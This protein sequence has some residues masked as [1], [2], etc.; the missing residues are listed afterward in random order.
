VTQHK[1]H[2]WGGW[3]RWTLSSFDPNK[4]QI[5]LEMIWGCWVSRW[6]IAPGKAPGGALH[7][8]VRCLVSWTE[9]IGLRLSFL[10]KKSKLGHLVF[11]RPKE[12]VLVVWGYNHIRPELN[13]IAKISAKY[14]LYHFP[15]Y[16][17]SGHIMGNNIVYGIISSRL[18]V[19]FVL[20]LLWL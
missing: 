12:H 4:C 8:A 9:K 20:R 1:Q 7:G 13:E 16:F 18:F 11:Q 15:Y 19:P 10:E 6:A 3:S 17:P 14:L 2:S 5:F